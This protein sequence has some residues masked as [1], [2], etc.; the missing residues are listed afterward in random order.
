MSTE[1]TPI[2]V[3]LEWRQRPRAAVVVP[4]ARAQEQTVIDY[5]VFIQRQG[6]SGAAQIQQSGD[7]VLQPHLAKALGEV[8]ISRDPGDTCSVSVSVTERGQ[9]KPTERNFDC[10]LAR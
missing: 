7:V 2:E 4:Y 3:W 8:L 10:P 6:A 5:R 9:K 1:A